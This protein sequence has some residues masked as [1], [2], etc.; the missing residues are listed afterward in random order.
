MFH[1]YSMPK[2][3]QK[4]PVVLEKK[5]ILLFLLYFSNSGHLGSNVTIL[6][7]RSQIML[8]AKFQ[9]YWSS[10]CTEG[11]WKFVFKCWRMTDDARRTHWYANSSLWPFGPGQLIIIHTKF[12]APEPSSSVVEDFLYILFLNPRPLLQDQ[13]GPGK[14]AF[15]FQPRKLL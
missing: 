6:R 10:S 1:W 15:W 14:W 13:F 3:S 4:Y 8:H 11:V 7:P 9:N 12:Q 5:F 2:F